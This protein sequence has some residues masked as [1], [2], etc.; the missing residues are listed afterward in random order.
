[1]N[2]YENVFELTDITSSEDEEDFL[3]R[4]STSLSRKYIPN[5]RIVLEIFHIRATLSSRG[6][7]RRRRML[8]HFDGLPRVEL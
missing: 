5:Y 2:S 8:R 1:M 3:E 4:A 6:D 7:S